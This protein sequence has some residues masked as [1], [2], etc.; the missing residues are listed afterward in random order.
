MKKLFTAE[1][2]TILFVAVIS[3]LIISSAILAGFYIGR[4]FSI[5]ALFLL[6]SLIAIAQGQNKADTF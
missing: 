3:L 4:G 5:S 6:I 1:N 2:I